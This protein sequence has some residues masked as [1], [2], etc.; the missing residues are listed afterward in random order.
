[1]S[2]DQALPKGGVYL[3]RNTKND[4]HYI[5]STKNV[6]ARLNTHKSNL[7]NNKH[8]NSY[9]QNAWNKYKEE[10]FEFVILYLT[11][12]KE[13]WLKLEQNWLDTINPAYNLS[14]TAKSSAGS[15]R[16]EETRA[17]LRKAMTDATRL[18]KLKERSEL[19]KSAEHKAKIA[20]SHIGLK[21]S[22]ETRAKLRIA[23]AKR[24]SNPKEVEKARLAK[25]GKPNP[26]KRID[27]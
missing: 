5:G 25:L 27:E 15:K 6:Q 19:P 17:K 22:D 18:Q 20:A 7:R 23:A 9:L 21:P 1:M 24:W 10:S 14:P 12:S 3:I 2:C 4:H 16:S 26:R 8:S 13:E 11:D